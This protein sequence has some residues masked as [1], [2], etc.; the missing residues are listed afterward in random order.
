MTDHD[1]TI[2]DHAGTILD[3]PESDTWEC[4]VCGYEGTGEPPDDLTGCDC[5]ELCSMGPTCPG[6]M[7]A[8]LE[9]A[10]CWRTT[11]RD[12]RWENVYAAI[13]AH[14]FGLLVTI[15]VGQVGA[16]TRIAHVEIA[17]T[18][19]LIRDALDYLVN[20]LDDTLAT[21]SLPDDPPARNSVT[22]R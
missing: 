6:G 21:V 19:S 12:S 20:M 13:E 9:G 8:G 17:T 16:T 1:G 2:C 15:E 11:G 7:L 22:P 3:R 14:P 18:P 10:G 4:L 5:D